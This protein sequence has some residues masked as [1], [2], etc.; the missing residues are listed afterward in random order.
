MQVTSVEPQRKNPKRF[1]IFLDGKFGFGAD[2]DLIVSY[3]LL[4][5]KEIDSPTLEKLLFEA[6]VGKLLER[7]YGL[8]SVR[9]RS[10]KEVRDYLR[11]LSFKRKVKGGEGLS[12]MM[13]ELLIERLKQKRLIDDEVFARAWVEARQRSKQKGLIALKVEL[14]RK[15]IAREIAER[16]ISD[17]SSAMSQEELAV[18]AIEKKLKSFEK[19]DKLTL[20]KKALE[21]LMR[22]G[23]EYEDARS[24]VEKVLTKG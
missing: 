3:R 8:F 16:V 11:N 7:M 12:E 23:Y 9:A 22:K 24:A 13:V 4:S 6:E 17:Q 5:G 1:N 19:Y 14:A 18:Q 20:K 2:E 10:E 21:F 15:G